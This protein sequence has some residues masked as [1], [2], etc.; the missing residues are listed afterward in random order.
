[1]YFTSSAL[2]ALPYFST[3]PDP[4][5]LITLTTAGNPYPVIE[6][7][8]DGDSLLGIPIRSGYQ[9]NYVLTSISGSPWKPSDSTKYDEL[10]VDQEAQVVPLYVIELNPDTLDD[11]AAK[12]K[13]ETPVFNTNLD[14]LSGSRK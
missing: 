2:Y 6:H 13:R 7:R 3:R 9:S 14:A 8:L 12:F 5:I 10:V 4:C 11:L 1:M